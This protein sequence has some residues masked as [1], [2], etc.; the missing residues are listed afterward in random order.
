MSLNLSKLRNLARFKSGI[1]NTA[2]LTN[3]D[4][5]DL[6]NI[7]YKKVQQEM[8]KINQDFFEEQKAK[9]DLVANQDLYALP[10]D[11]LAMKQLRLA[12]STPSDESD[13]KIAI[14]HDAAAT[15]DV[16]SQEENVSSANPIYDLTGNYFRIKPTPDSNVSNGGEIYYFARCSDLSST[17]DVPDIPSDYHDIIA[18]YAAKEA[19]FRFQLVNRYN[20]LVN[21]WEKEIAR[22]KEA[23]AVRETNPGKRIRNILEDGGVKSTTELW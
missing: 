5:D 18:I 17:A 23:L 9:F 20:G 14:P 22:M 6:I 13:Y 1:T 16:S 21:E 8:V 12:Y 4:L 3:A 7:G 10:D 19:A 2:T 15:K 11:F